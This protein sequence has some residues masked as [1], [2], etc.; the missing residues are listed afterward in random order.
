MPKY[1]YK[2]NSCLE[3]FEVFHGMSE[4]HEVCNFCFSTDIHRVPQSVSIKRQVT[5]KG[6][7]VG[8]E[9]KRAIEENRALLREEKSKRV[10]LDDGN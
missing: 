1:T 2:C 4:D 8:D 5:N 3:A 9:V 7:K 10:E 6:S